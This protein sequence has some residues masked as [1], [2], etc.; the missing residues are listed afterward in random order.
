MGTPRE[1]KLSTETT[2]GPPKNEAWHRFGSLGKSRESSQIVILA[3]VIGVL[4][5]Q[6]QMAPRRLPMRGVPPPEADGYR[7]TR[8]ENEAGKRSL[9]SFWQF[10]EGWVGFDL[11]TEGV[12]RCSPE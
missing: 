8:S 6:W 9:A 2:K 1:S 4:R 11:L 5:S 3:K 12:V 10:R 7:E